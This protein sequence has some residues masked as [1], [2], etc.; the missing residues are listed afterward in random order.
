MYN[1]KRS[2]DFKKT[3]KKLGKK[4]IRKFEIVKRKIK[5]LAFSNNLN[6]YKNLKKPLQKF[7]RVHT[8]SFVILFRI[9][10]ENNVLYL[11]KFSHHD[12]IYL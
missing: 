5:E 9:D 8:G 6:H 1:I 10:N 3:L 2:S 11:E 12:N 4:D 7:K